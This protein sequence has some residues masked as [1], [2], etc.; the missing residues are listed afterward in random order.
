MR[1]ATLRHV[2]HPVL[3]LVVEETLALLGSDSIVGNRRSSG[4]PH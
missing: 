2:R 3:R 1:Q 4:D